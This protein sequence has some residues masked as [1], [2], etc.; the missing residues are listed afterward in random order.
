VPRPLAVFDRIDLRSKKINFDSQYLY[1]TQPH[2]SGN[3]S[4]RKDFIAWAAYLP[5]SV[6]D[7]KQAINIREGLGYQSKHDIPFQ[8][9]DTVILPGVPK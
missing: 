8:E 9:T 5:Y 2:R 7:K 6:V 1:R 3:G 4:G